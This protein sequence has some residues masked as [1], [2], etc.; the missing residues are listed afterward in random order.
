MKTLLLCTVYA[1]FALAGACLSLAL[2]SHIDFA[3][4]M[5]LAAA[6]FGIAVFGLIEA[7]D[8]QL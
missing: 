3:E 6:S 5:V 4:G 2:V 8:C 7:K 1:S